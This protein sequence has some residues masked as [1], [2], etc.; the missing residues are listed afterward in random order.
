MIRRRFRTTNRRSAEMGIWT[1]SLSFRFTVGTR[2]Y[3]R[4]MY[5]NTSYELITKVK[6]CRGTN[7]EYWAL[8]PPDP[9]CPILLCISEKSEIFTANA[10]CARKHNSDQS[11][12]LRTKSAVAWR[13]KM[14]TNS[15]QVVANN[16]GTRLKRVLRF[17]LVKNLKLRFPCGFFNCLK[18][19]GPF[20]RRPLSPFGT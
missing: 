17:C 7:N 19:C 12:L 20:R 10:W 1:L 3:F 11:S 16:A 14:N 4:D 9:L 13:C 18:L 5:T 6:R 2:V 8:S 15:R